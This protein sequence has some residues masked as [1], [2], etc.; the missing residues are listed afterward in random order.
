[1]D[2]ASAS[3]F[4]GDDDLFASV[5][6]DHLVAQASQER[7]SSS[8]TI[9]SSQQALPPSQPPSSSQPAAS[10]QLPPPPS[11]LQCLSTAAVPCKENRGAARG[12]VRG[13]QQLNTL[14]SSLE[15]AEREAWT[16]TDARLHQGRSAHNLKT[17]Q[18]ELKVKQAPRRPEALTPAGKRARRD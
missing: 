4:D 16:Q 12:K 1:M 15:T 6:L 18:Y 17:D 11:G 9:S 13:S 7:L 8:Q 14:F 10:S 2:V 5:D 3:F